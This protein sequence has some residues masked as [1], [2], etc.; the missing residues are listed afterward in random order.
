MHYYKNHYYILLRHYYIIITSFLSL[1]ITSLLHHDYILL[2]IRYYILLRHYCDIITSS[3]YN[4][5]SLLLISLLHFI[6]S[7]SHH[8]YTIIT[9]LF[10]HYY[11]WRNDESI[12]TYYDIGCS[13]YSAVITYYYLLLPIITYLRQGN[14]QMYVDS[15]EEMLLTSF[16]LSDC[17][18]LSTPAPLFSNAV[19]HARR[20]LISARNSHQILVRSES[21][22]FHSQVS[23]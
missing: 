12:I 2:Q 4:Y 16:S 3:L 1:I 7:L 13:H 8:Y 19:L 9:S 23:S 18:A 5:Y 6:T 11:K 21:L 22:C 14:L 20:S 10:R 17:F 15:N